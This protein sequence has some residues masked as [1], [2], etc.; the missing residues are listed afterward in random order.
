MASGEWFSWWREHGE[1]FVHVDR[2][3]TDQWRVSVWL[4]S[5][6]V[7]EGTRRFRRL[8]LAGPRRIIYCVE[9]S[10]I[11]AIAGDARTG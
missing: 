6:C 1:H 4:A 2:I 8:V 10:G 9:H 11:G 3:S 5:T 7:L